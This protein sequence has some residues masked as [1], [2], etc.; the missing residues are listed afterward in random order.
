MRRQKAGRLNEAD[1]ARRGWHGDA[2][3]PH[4]AHGSFRRRKNHA[5]QHSQFSKSRRTQNRRPSVHQWTSGYK[6]HNHDVNNDDYN[7]DDHHVEK[8]MDNDN[9]DDDNDD[10]DNDDDDNDDNVNDNDDN[11]YRNILSSKNDD[12]K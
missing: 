9:E 6:D 7:V 1:F 5:P 3:Q 4:G 12:N 10:D 11:K 8:Y 2:V